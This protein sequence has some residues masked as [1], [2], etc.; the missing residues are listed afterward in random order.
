MKTVGVNR[1]SVQ[2]DPSGRAGDSG[3]DIFE[4]QNLIKR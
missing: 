2:I 3:R 4:K 1:G